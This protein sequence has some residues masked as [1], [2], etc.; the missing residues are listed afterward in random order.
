ME[1]GYWVAIF[2]VS[3]NTNR[4]LSNNACSASS[5]ACCTVTFSRGSNTSIWMCKQIVCFTTLAF[6]GVPIL[7]KGSL[8]GFVMYKEVKTLLSADVPA[9]TGCLQFYDIRALWKYFQV[10]L[11]HISNA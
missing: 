9:I 8:R 2:T 3:I 4:L 6:Y 11:E 1:K 5:N 7:F 10:I